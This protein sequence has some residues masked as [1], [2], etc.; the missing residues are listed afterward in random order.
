MG[1][2]TPTLTTALF[3]FLGTFALWQSGLAL[4]ALAS[5]WWIAGRLRGEGAEL[6]IVEA[7]LFGAVGG[8]LGGTAGL[9]IGLEVLASALKSV[10]PW[11]QVALDAM[12]WSLAVGPVFGLAFWALLMWDAASSQRKAAT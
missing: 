3:A 7:I 11:W 2:A 8:V 12:P 1:D 5:V 6:T 10:P 4:G 9:M